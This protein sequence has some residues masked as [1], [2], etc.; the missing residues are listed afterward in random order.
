V[1]ILG[2]GPAGLGA[3]YKLAKRDICQVTLIEQ[4]PRVGGN[5]GSFE[6]D[7]M[8][9]DYGSHRLHPSCD[10]GILSD[11]R[12]LLDGDL[13]DRPRHGR[14]RLKNRWIHFP[15]KP[16]DLLLRLP[17]GFALGTMR[18]Q[19][20][21]ALA[22]SVKRGDNINFASVMQN[23]LG[24]TICKEFY[25]PYARKIW[26][27]APED[28][29]PEQAQRRV[30]ANSPGKIIKKIFGSLP[31]LRKPGTG[32]FYYPRLGYGQISESYEA[33]A[34]KLGAQVHLQTRVLSIDFRELD[35]IRVQ[36]E[37]AGEC[38]EIQ[39]DYL[40]STIPIT[41]LASLIQPA[42]PSGLRDGLEHLDYRSMVL[43][44]LVVGQAQFS[45]FDAHYFPGLE[46][47]ITRLSEPKNYSGTDQ[48]SG[49]TVLC[50]EIPCSPSD[51][52]WSASEE[53]LKDLLSNALEKAGIPIRASIHKVEVKR[54]RYAYP[55]YTAGFEEYFYALDDWLR[56]FVRLLTFGRQGLF[57]H[58][59]THHAL[60]MAYSAVDCLDLN[61]D[62]DH[63]KWQ[64]YREVFSTHVVED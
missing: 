63:T 32:R 48:P 4:N 28:L 9:V 24:E 2:G 13:L 64:A 42:M 41:R 51:S 15:L 33:A 40:W 10:P 50:A 54:L 39:A 29:S 22:S 18:D 45:P 60:F 55:I 46:L 25:F 5:A 17:P 56:Q 19:I 35:Q 26:G 47:P 30:S 16:F 7:G 1:L 61:G 23:N 34:R 58:D 37:Q 27:I 20:K 62:F 31:G 52:V 53:E 12:S 49:S 44:Y 6:L 57:A 3:A 43:V 38:I 36:V 11:I 21:K 14:I 59:N 8:R